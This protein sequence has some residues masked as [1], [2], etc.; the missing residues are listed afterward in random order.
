MNGAVQMSEAA[1]IGIHT[2]LWLAAQKGRLCRS[3]EICRR[4]CFSTAHFAK[5]MQSLARA[6]IVESV[7]GPR[8]GTRLAGDPAGITLL[9]V[10]E[11]LEG[12]MGGERC[13]L[14]PRVCPSRCCPLGREIAR[15]NRS[16]RATLAKATL[17]KMAAETDWSGLGGA[18]PDFRVTQQP[19]KK[20][21]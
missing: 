13:L 8:G 21:E 7:R 1:S 4:F 12:P 3:A 16:L 6:G 19:V 17:A 10:Y 9:A 11:A 20:G 14:S 15:L 5:V 18:K 2:A